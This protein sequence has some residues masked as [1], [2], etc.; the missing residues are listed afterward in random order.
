MPGEGVE[1][2]ARRR[3]REEMGIDCEMRKAFEFKYEADVGSGLTEKEY[4]HVFFANY[5]GS[6]RPN[7]QEVEDWRWISLQD[8]KKGIDASPKVYTPWLVLMIDK[9]IETYGN[10]K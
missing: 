9:V 8:L 3:L 10:R 4:D 6:P 5:E 1:E 7:P 2:A